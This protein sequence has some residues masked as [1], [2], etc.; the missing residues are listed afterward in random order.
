ML[1]KEIGHIENASVQDNPDISFLGVLRNLV[2]GKATGC[3]LLFLSW[4][5]GEAFIVSSYDPPANLDTSTFPE[6]P[7]PE[8]SANEVAFTLSP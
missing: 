4:C 3:L 5:I 2:H 6:R 8:S 1:G 7:P